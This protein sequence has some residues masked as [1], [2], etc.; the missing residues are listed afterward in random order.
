MALQVTDSE[1][2]F[3]TI[4]STYWRWVGLGV[5]VTRLEAT[6]TLYAYINADAFAT[7]KTNISQ[8]QFTVS[9]TD[10]LTFANQIDGDSPVG[11]STAI[12]GYVK[13]SDPYF[14]DAT[15]A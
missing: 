4:S 6:V 9:G 15:D 14:A 3:G 8:K 5:D 11:L 12:Y 2:P 7:G 10:F 1:T 13:S